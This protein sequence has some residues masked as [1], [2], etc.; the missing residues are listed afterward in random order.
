MELRS[1]GWPLARQ[2]LNT[3]GI[4]IKNKGVMPALSLYYNE[5][6]LRKK[7]SLQELFFNMPFIH[8][9]YCLTY[10]SQTEMF[11][12]LT[13]CAYGYDA[14][15]RQ[16]YFTANLSKDFAS[17]RII[18]RLPLSIIANPSAGPTAIRSQAS[19]SFLKPKNPTPADIHNLSG[20][21]QE[22]R[23]DL[24]Y[25]NGAETLWY[26]KA[27][28]SG[29]QRL[30]RQCLTLVLAAMHRLSEICRY[31]PMSLASHLS[32]QK[33]WLLSEF[34]D[35]SSAQFVDEIASEITG[36]EFLIPNIPAA[37]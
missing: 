20:L 10:K 13:D 14:A 30:A 8:R 27:I 24:Y 31:Q 4:E 25:I 32:G 7:D 17:K 3:V 18:N 12:P 5:K 2:S 36:H 37:T 9:T 15:T 26:T 28:T 6:E 33:N 34:I 21:H 22:L 23:G 29:P 11:V 16:A 19:V 1:G 35:M